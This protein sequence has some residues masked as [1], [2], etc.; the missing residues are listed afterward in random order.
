M[1]VEKAYSTVDSVR[2]LDGDIK[3]GGTIGAFREE[4][5]A[6]GFT[7]LPLIIIAHNTDYTNS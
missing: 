5:S 1:Y 6:P 4:Q 2:P 3:P 7:S